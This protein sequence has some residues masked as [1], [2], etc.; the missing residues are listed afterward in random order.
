[1]GEPQTTDTFTDAQGRRYIA[2]YEVPEAV[3]QRLEQ[4]AALYDALD[5]LHAWTAGDLPPD[6]PLG[7][8]VFAA[9][10]QARGEA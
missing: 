8:K 7:R 1:M 2:G 3:W 5:Q 9:L 10:R 6:S 4:S